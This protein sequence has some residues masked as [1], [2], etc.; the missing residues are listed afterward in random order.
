MAGSPQSTLCAWSVS[1]NKRSPNG[2]SLASSPM[3]QRGKGKDPGVLLHEAAGQGMCRC[4]NELGHRESILDRGNTNR[5]SPAP[6]SPK[7]ASAGYFPTNPAF[8]PPQLQAA[9]VNIILPR[10]METRT[11]SL[12]QISDFAA[13]PP[14]GSPFH[15]PTIDKEATLGGLGKAEQSQVRRWSLRREH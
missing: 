9:H 5:T 13:F 4:I 8:T 6:T 2:P 14:V 3:E 15:T 1:S 7:K 12:L 11:N 10:F